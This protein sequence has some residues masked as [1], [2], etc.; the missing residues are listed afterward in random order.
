MPYTGGN[1]PSEFQTDVDFVVAN[2]VRMSSTPNQKESLNFVSTGFY[3]QLIS[4]PKPLNI[5]RKLLKK[6]DYVQP[7]FAQLR[8]VSGGA[9]ERAAAALQPF[10]PNLPCHRRRAKAQNECMNWV[11]SSILSCGPSIAGAGC[12]DDANADAQAAH[13]EDHAEDGVVAAEAE[14]LADNAMWDGAE[15]GAAREENGTPP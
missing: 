13:A 10:M 1:T 3:S 9:S 14:E 7:L 4:F 15:Q 8:M 11:C 6:L 2:A 12:N 5:I